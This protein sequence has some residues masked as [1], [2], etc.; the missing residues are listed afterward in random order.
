[1]ITCIARTILTL[2]FYRAHDVAIKKN[3]T[4][5]IGRDKVDFK[6]Q[7]KYICE[8]GNKAE[9]NRLDTQPYI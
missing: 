2:L 7:V 3:N 4:N 6:V 9:L 8:I 5:K 1:M